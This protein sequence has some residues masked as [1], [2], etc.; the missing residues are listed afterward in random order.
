MSERFIGGE[1]RSEDQ[2]FEWSLRPRRLEEFIGQ[3][4]VK[5]NLEILVRA[6]HGRNEPIEHKHH[7]TR[8]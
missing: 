4:A 7:V 3:E 5:A 2:E 1:Q 8:R 6:A